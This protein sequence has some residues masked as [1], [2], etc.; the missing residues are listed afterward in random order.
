MLSKEVLGGLN[1][2]MNEEYFAGDG[3]MGMG[4]YCEKECYE[5]FG[6]FYIEEGKEEGLEGK[7]MYE[8]M[9]DGGE[10]GIFVR[11]KVGKVEFFFI[12]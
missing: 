5:G 9:N 2:E 8:Y 7:K 3:Y 10:D 11:I 4:G 1:E 12:L 6:N